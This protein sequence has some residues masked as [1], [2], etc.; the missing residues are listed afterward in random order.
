V[1]LYLGLIE[2]PAPGPHPAIVHI[3]HRGPFEVPAPTVELITGRG[4]VLVGLD[5]GHL[6]PDQPGIVGPAQAAYPEGKHDWATLAVW[7]W[8]A[9]RALD[10]LLTLKSVDGRRVVVTG[11]SR[12]GKAALLAGALDERFALVAPAG[13]GCAGAAVYRDKGGGT[14][15]LEAITR[16]FPHWFVPRLRAFAGKERRLPFDQ[17]FLYALVAPRPLLT[18]DARD[19]RWA[20]PP[21]TQQAHLAA[22]EVYAFLGATGRLGLNLRPGRHELA[23]EDWLALLDF[24]DQVLPGGAKRTGGRRFDQLPFPAQGPRFSWRAPR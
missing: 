20:D 4:Y 11:H 2:P 16:S 15:T 6:D 1:K 7:A 18:L 22:R 9:S 24:A 21:G 8:G 14:E 19:D 13:S 10:H 12:S 23:H 5:P 3:D 17:H